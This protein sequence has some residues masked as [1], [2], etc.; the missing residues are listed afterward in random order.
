[1]TTEYDPAPWTNTTAVFVGPGDRRV[2]SNGH[3]FPVACRV[4]SEP[5]YQLAMKA[6][7]AHDE[8]VA[9]LEALQQFME[10]MRWT[11]DSDN[12]RA[13]ELD[14]MALDALTLARGGK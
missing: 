5:N 10:P 14:K 6:V 13:D 11:R 3:P 8:L 12:A 1:M 9:A 2:I 4:L 7:N